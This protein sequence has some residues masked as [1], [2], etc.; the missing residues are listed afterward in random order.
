MNEYEVR[1]KNY[2]QNNNIEAEH[3][4]FDQSCHSV[5]E[6]AQAVN[7][8]PEDFVKNICMVDGAGNLIV[9]IVKGE[10]QASASRVGKALHTAGVRMAT[11]DEILERTGY[12]CGGTPSFGFEATF[13]VDQR[14]PETEIVYTGGGSTTSLVK[15][16]SQELIRA[17]HAQVVRIRR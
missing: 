17:N 16:A 12:P 11:P 5:E 7:A 1:L 8:R 4:S 3:L 13:L 9:A 6:A 2:I 14:V 10:N 15:I